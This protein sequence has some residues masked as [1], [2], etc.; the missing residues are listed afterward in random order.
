MNSITFN[1]SWLSEFYFRLRMY[2]AIIELPSLVAAFLFFFVVF[3]LL[4]FSSSYSAPHESSNQSLKT[5][6]ALNALLLLFLLFC[7]QQMILE[8][9]HD[10]VA[11]TRKARQQTEMDLEDTNRLHKEVLSQHN[12]AKKTGEISAL[13]PACNV[14]CRNLCCSSVSSFSP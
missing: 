8:K 9:C 12:S 14:I 5:C 2:C 10:T 6:L 1:K 7:R 3:L 13:L 4:Q 11:R